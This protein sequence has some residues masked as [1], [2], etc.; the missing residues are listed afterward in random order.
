MRPALWLAILALA[1]LGRWLHSDAV[2]AAIVPVAL[3]FFLL[4]TP[5]GLRGAIVVMA[6]FEALAWAIG[7]AA[8]MLDLLP[9]IIAAFIGWLFA[10]SLIA[11]RTAL[12]AR[13]IAAIEGENYLHDAAIARYAQR[14]TL[15]WAV[16]QF[17]L[18]LLCALCLLRSHGWMFA[19]TLPP[20]RTFAATV[21]PLAVALLFFGEFFLRRWLLPAYPRAVDWL[22][23]RLEADADAAEQA[24]DLLIS[25]SSAAIHGLVAPRSRA[26]A[27]S[28]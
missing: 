24:P 28:G 6:V 21:L 17:G 27:S 11:P 14:L 8:M 5:P 12:I 15:L 10:R 13:A 22:S 26:G 23:R 7:G 4:A 9:A 18:A 16:F 20:P 19:A 1:L 25:T 2:T 3:V